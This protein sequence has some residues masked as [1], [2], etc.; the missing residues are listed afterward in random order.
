[1][2][3]LRHTDRL[4]AAPVRYESY[5]PGSLLH[6]YH[7]KLFRFPPCVLHL[8]LGWSAAPYHKRSRVGYDHF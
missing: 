2:S 3:L 5:H 6:F 8:V 7:K 1:M 4:T